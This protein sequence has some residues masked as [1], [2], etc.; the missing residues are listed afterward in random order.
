MKGLRRIITGLAC[1]LAVLVLPSVGALGGGAP[2]SAVQGSEKTLEKSGS[3]GEIGSPNEGPTHL[4]SLS[5][6]EATAGDLS[7]GA[8]PSMKAA[9]PGTPVAPPVLPFSSGSPLGTLPSAGAELQVPSVEQLSSDALSR[10]VYVNLDREA[11]VSLAERTFNIGVPSW[12]APGSEPGS[13]IV[14]YLSSDTASEERPGGRQVLVQSTLPLQVADGSGQE[15]PV[16]AAL[17]DTGSAYVPSNPL[18]PVSIS[19]VAATGASFLSSGLSVVPLSAAAREE[20][21]VVGNRV[22]WANTAA[23]TDFMT[24]P[25]PG[26]TGIEDSW[27]LRSQNSPEENGL[28]FHL[29][30]GASL[31]MS[32]SVPGGAEVMMEGRPLLLIPP[33]SAQQADGSPIQASYRVEGDRL[34]THVSLAGDIDFPVMVDPEVIGWYGEA[35]N[36]NAWQNWLKYNECGFGPLEYYNLIQTGTNPGGAVGCYGEWYTGV[37]NSN[38]AGITRVDVT[39]VIHQPA[40]QSSLQ[41]GITESNGNEIWTSNG[42]AGAMGT[43]PLVTA[44]EYY[45]TPM[46]FC[47][48][49][50]GGHDGGE[51][52]LCNECKTWSEARCVEA[53]DGKVFYF[54]DDLWQEP[55]TVYNYARISSATIHYIQ[56]APPTLA[57]KSYIQSGWTSGSPSIVVVGE[58]SGIGASSVGLDVASGI[59]SAERMPAPGSSP[60]PGTSPYA[61]ACNDPFCW[62]VLP[63]EFVASLSTGVWTLGAWVKDAVGLQD[64]QTYSA[65]VDKTPP[66]ISESS[67]NNETVGDGAHVLKFS[68]DDG[69]PSE[70]QSGVAW[71]EVYV[72]GRDVQNVSQDLENCPKPEGAHIIQTEACFGL[73]GEWTLRGED[74][75]VGPHTVSIHAEDWAGNWAERSFH[76]TVDHPVGESQPVGPGSLNLLSGDYTLGATDVTLPAGTATLSVARSYSSQSQEPAGPL[77]PGWMLSLPDATGGGQWQSLQVLPEG[78]IE[79]TTTAGEKVVFVPN[80]HEGYTSP[81]GFATYAMT[82]PIKNPVTYQI[83][84][85]GGNYTQ[86][87]EPA[88]SSVFLPT[89]VA[90]AVQNGGLNKITYTLSEGRTSEVVGPAPGTENCT[91]TKPSEWAKGREIEEEH[92]GCRVLTLKY[93]TSATTAHGENEDEW[94]SF[95]GQLESVAFTSWSTVENKLITVSVAK[96]EYDALGR[97]RAEW[98]PRI[99]PALKTTYGY[100]AEGHVTA[101]SPP[102]QESWAFHYGTIVGDPSTGRLLS[103]TRPNAEMGI[104]KGEPL[105]NTNVPRL[106]GSP[107]VGIT[108][109]VKNGSWSGIPFAYSYQWEDCNASGAAC[110]PVLGAT[111][112]TYKVVHSDEGH[113]LVVHVT[114]TSGA[115]S[116]MASTYPSVVV[117]KFI[118]GPSYISSFGSAGS[119][120]GE[121]SHPGDVTVDSK[122]DLWVVDHGN[123]R[124]EEFSENGEYLKSFGS[125]GSGDG[126]FNTP[127]GLAIDS[128]GNVW[129]DDH[130]NSRIE[131][132]NEKGEY[133]KAFGSEGSGNGQM[134]RPEG[135]AVAS[136]GD[137][138]VSDTYN[139]RLDVFNEK[140]EFLKTVGSKGSGAGQLGEPEGIAIDSRGDVLVADWSNDRVVEFNESGEYVREFGSAGSG[141]GQ[142]SNPYGI[143]VDASGNT[144]VIDTGNNRVEE[145]S[146]DGEYITQF[147]KAGEGSENFNLSYPAGLTLDSK[148]H[149]WIT[150]S[151]GNSIEEWLTGTPLYVSEFG[152]S[153]AGVGQFS[154][155]GDIAVDAKGDLWVLDHGNSRVEEFS[156]SGEY[157]QKFGSPG[158]GYGQLS[159][160]DSLTVDRHGNVWV[161]DTGNSRVEEF[162]EKGGYVKTFGSSGSGNGQLKDPE[163]IAVDA[164]GNIWV[165]DTYNDRLEEFNAKGEFSKIIGSGDGEPEGLAISNG[166]IW[167]ADW[168]QNRIQEYNEEGQLIR[169]FGVTGSGDGQ[170]TH[171]YGLAVEDEIVWV[172]DIGNNRVEEF[173]E[174]GEYITQ[175]GGAGT[176][177]GKFGF[178]YPIGL[179][180]DA[181]GDVWV[182]NPGGNTIEKWA[183]RVPIV[184]GEIPHAPA[185]RWT[186]EY[187]VPFSG[188]DLPSMSKEAVDKW[189]EKDNPWEATAVFPPD[190]S[191]GWPAN[192]YRRATVSYFD[193]LGRL[194]N[195]VTPGERV[196]TT[197]YNAYDNQE[198]T[199]TPGNR[200][201]A[202]ESS[203]PAKSAELLATKSEYENE[204]TEL[205]TRLGPQHE[206]RLASGSNVEARAQTKYF[207]DEGA[208]SEGGPY[209]LVT[210]TVEGALL[211]NG[212]EEE[213]RTIKDVY[214][215]QNNLGWKI[216]KPTT[217]TIEP[218]SGKPITRV[219]TYS[220]E[221]GD[222]TETGSP[223]SGQP[224]IMEYALP[225]GSKPFGMTT[226]PDKNLW[227]TD[228]A[229]GQVGKITPSG[230]ITEYA[231]DGDEPEGITSGPDGNLWFVEHSIRHVNH[232]T[233]AGTLSVYTL[234]RTGTYNVGIAAGPDENLWFTEESTGYVGKINVKDEVLAEY[235]LP[236][237]SKPHGISEGPD[238]NLWFTDYGTSK[239]GKVTTAGAISEYALP[240]GS[241]PYWITPGP[242]GNMWF[243]DYGTGKVGKI[244]ASGAVTEYSLPSGSEPRGITAGSEGD[245]WVSEYGT[246]KIAK[247]TIAGVITEYALP[248][249]S[250][251]GGITTGPE[252]HIWFAEYGTSR[253]GTLDPE[254]TRSEISQTVY[255][256]AGTEAGVI[257]C[258]EHPEWASLPCQSRPTTQP[259]DDLPEL[260]TMTTTYNMWGE[261]V[262]TDEKSGSSTRSTTNTYDSAG[263]L[264]ESSVSSSTGKPVPK[265]VDSYSSTTGELID[266]STTSEGKHEAVESEFNALG[267]IT[268]YTDAAGKTT[269]FEYD[270]DGRVKRVSNGEGF[271]VSEYSEITGE[272][273]SLRDSGAGTFTATYDTDGQIA[274]ET[275]PNG[276][277]VTYTTNS[278]G[279]NTGLSYVKGSSTWYEDHVA[280]SIHGQWL[281]QSSTL[282]NDRYTYDSAGRMIEVQEEAIGKV[283]EEAVGKGC[284]TY[285]YGYDAASDRTNETKRSPGTG[286]ICASEGGTTTG[287]GYDE[288]GRLVDAGVAYEAFGADTVLPAADAGG[289]TLESS[290]YANGRLYSE[291]QSG[292]TNT[293]ELDPVGRTLETTTI[294]GMSSK[295]TISH[296]CGGGS[297][298]CWTETEGSVTRNITGIGG[299]LVATQANQDEPTIEL[300]NLHGDVI[301]TTL[302]NGGAESVSLKS[303]PTA[304]GVPTSTGIE[305]LGWLGGGGLQVEFLE[306]GIQS[307]TG[308]AYIPQLGLHLEPE[309]LSGSAS[310]DPVNEYLADQ[311]LAQPTGE[312]TSTAAGV[313]EPSPVNTRV[314]EEFWAEPPWDRA[315]VN[316]DPIHNI[317]LV[318]PS[319]AIAWGKVLCNC[320]VD[321]AVGVVVEA[322]LGELGLEGGG[323]FIENFLEE[324]GPVEALGREL[325]TCGEATESNKLNRCVIEL[326]TLGILGVDTGIP[327]G[328]SVGACYYFKKSYK[329]MKAK[330]LHCADGAEYRPPY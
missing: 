31:Q 47:A 186:V 17:V 248:A 267:E 176:G 134:N 231:G 168:A 68:A 72:D 257:A 175:F 76:I 270:E 155:P 282:A 239:I 180:V 55:Q 261:A 167:V 28:V 178:S 183:L 242:D 216:H 172:A 284:I 152:S 29:P 192:N 96:Y 102:G 12:V 224:S 11:V 285:M 170:F 303:E 22:I 171:P 188:E 318:T 109:S 79:A 157:I 255:Y 202:I 313:I 273:I 52:P 323:E 106:S 88:G 280:L 240:S 105:E 143:A 121:F 153:G 154:H 228:E 71:M 184:E 74:Y 315:P 21:V 149:I 107:V 256:S 290:Y 130:G 296:Y 174:A 132:F 16:S 218:E 81:T 3:Q 77:G 98:D 115:G 145:F 283:Q 99:E 190:E 62:A 101:I 39:N 19:K 258:E 265:V 110:S 162:T 299:T 14:R 146:E 254:I 232:L 237:G 144:W 42:Y 281:S 6:S 1:C 286:G 41:I 92:R 219:T 253:I 179:G 30:P 245:L 249:G 94:G 46:A 38:S 288:A 32:S 314:E 34:M 25:A 129:V 141:N 173:N 227:F 194:V 325:L 309:E 236:S 238:K 322:I 85:P 58:D 136:N 50:A 298:P 60:A 317:L 33:A 67:W 45:D 163:G 35:G 48:D 324:S 113:R 246:S 266:Q 193:S 220:P 156:E 140:G 201:L 208:P 13:R 169:Q 8:M 43:A 159:G 111:N 187:R 160:P 70:P 259:G 91:S 211:E 117:G 185:P 133:V 212:K 131:E 225:A 127:D 122:G 251:P 150:F 269:S 221:T 199:L 204:G 274:S 161:A 116:V 326:H 330:R 294:K 205:K 289:Q 250:E 200:Q 272:L 260:P 271:Q 234:T 40:N 114:A 263:R 328:V 247:L 23:T 302:D 217:V 166:K 69:T 244:T 275:Y 252:G 268:S 148:G 230:G 75:G 53:Y 125:A 128:H 321:H 138:W 90:Q 54:L 123:D 10:T 319:N 86:F 196:S 112:P 64:E 177:S 57:N 51:Q 82:E 287:H 310:Q 37:S 5:P 305:K 235:A 89:T 24:E 119:G 191:V 223:T 295:A 304:F 26:G 276:M 291:S 181:N 300:L 264:K 93:D 182:T 95:K 56:T 78:G 292:Q 15:A 103:I 18:V 87:S 7:K 135:V 241:D 210:K 100:D 243:T 311:G 198:W 308:G 279:E 27:Q 312:Y 229:S 206:V 316:E 277:K 2:S 44:N 80:G 307:S 142:L 262:S 306:T 137:I 97:L 84:A 207:Y 124:V 329:G 126:E 49:G 73:S 209:R 203:E 213:D 197:Q 104:W 20:P 66:T 233:P 195:V 278:V 147:G 151:E 293:Y 222:V 320:T 297:T 61:P 189:N 327:T 108:M 214:S 301:G 9:E 158:T 118:P 63:H 139:G 59:V 164:H 83:T 165:S 36:D 215:G 65:Y 4:G 226:G 120:E